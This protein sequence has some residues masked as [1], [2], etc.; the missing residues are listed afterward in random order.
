MLSELSLCLRGHRL[1]FGRF[2][3]SGLHIT[4]LNI[5]I[6]KV[7]IVAGMVEIPVIDY[8]FSGVARV[9]YSYKNVVHIS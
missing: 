8:R 7:V 3:G 4:L 5:G 2:Y 1:C 9:Y 6:I